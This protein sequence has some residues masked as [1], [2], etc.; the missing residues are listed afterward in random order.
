VLIV[1]GA[2]LLKLKS[3][4]KSAFEPIKSLWQDN[5]SRYMLL[6]AF[7][8]SFLAPFFKKAVVCSSPYFALWVTLLLSTGL[9]TIFHLVRK[10]LGGLFRGLVN[11]FSILL[12][13]SI[14]SF[15]AAVAL[16]TAF[17]LGLTS[18]VI[19]VKRTSIL[20]TVILGYVFFKEDHPL[21][22]LIIGSIMVAGVVLISLG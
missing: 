22:S 8:F 10:Q 12:F 7:L 6:A 4:R 2:Y 15:L 17:D 1:S 13:G 20:F 5:S 11:H 14:I 19:S 9:L 16:F 18:Y 3:I 21:K